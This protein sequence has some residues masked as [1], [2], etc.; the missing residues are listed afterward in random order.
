MP[1]GVV[2]FFPIGRFQ[3][4]EIIQVHLTQLRSRHL[5]EVLHGNILDSDVWILKG[6]VQDPILDVLA[7]PFLRYLTHPGVRAVDN[8]NE[9]QSSFLVKTLNPNYVNYMYETRSQ[10]IGMEAWS[11]EVLKR[12]CMYV[13]IT[14]RF[15][16]TF[17]SKTCQGPNRKCTEWSQNNLKHLIDKSTLHTLNIHQRDPNFTLSRSKTSCIRDTRLS[18]QEAQGPWRSAWT[19]DPVHKNVLKSVL[20]RICYLRY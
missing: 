14:Q 13:C 9:S 1:Q 5:L 7:D 6:H 20:N 8:W 11:T 4:D 16:P 15:R 10:S 12:I 18:R 17:R 3:V 19:E 2:V